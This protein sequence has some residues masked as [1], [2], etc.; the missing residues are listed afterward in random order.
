MIQKLLA[1]VL[2]GILLAVLSSCENFEEEFEYEV[3]SA[4]YEF[5]QSS[6]IARVANRTGEFLSGQIVKLLDQNYSIGKFG[7][8]YLKDR[9]MNSRGEHVMHPESGMIFSFFPILESDVFVQGVERKDVAN[10]FVDAD[11]SWEMRLDQK[12]SLQSQ[13]AVFSDP[14]GFNISGQIEVEFWQ[15]QLDNL[16]DWSS[17]PA[18]MPSESRGSKAG[19]IVFQRVFSLRFLSDNGTPLKLK[20]GS[21]I[22][23]ENPDI[24]DQLK[25]H[26]LWFF[27]TEKAYWKKKNIQ[28]IDNGFLLDQAGYWAIGDE[29]NE[30]LLK[31]DLSLDGVPAI[32]RQLVV[33]SEGRI[34]QQTRTAKNGAFRIYLPELPRARLVLVDSEQDL[35]QEWPLNSGV[36]QDMDLGGL[37]LSQDNEVPVLLRGEV[38]AC[39]NQLTETAMILVENGPDQ[40][41]ISVPPEEFEIELSSSNGQDL[42]TTA[43]DL[44]T[45]E[46]GP[47]VKWARARVNTI[48]LFPLYSCENAKEEYMTLEIEGDY[49]T[50]WTGEYIE[51]NG[52][53]VLENEANPSEFVRLFLNDLSPGEISDS[54]LNFEFDLPRIGDNGYSLSCINSRVGCG[55][56]R[57]VITQSGEEGSR[58]VRGFFEGRFWVRK[59]PNRAVYRDISGSFQIER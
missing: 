58:W 6:V 16:N 35:Q 25:V 31:G 59:L 49:Q 47:R 50:F 17:F 39:D 23:M 4:Q 20:E 10:A 40:Y 44:T 46:Q 15:S 56:E 14:A 33:F 27:D 8:T 51:E 54:L 12:T 36:S 19:R 55:F 1:I 52:R 13:N 5:Y 29:S 9:K 30:H 3:N 11:Q 42:Y 38:R 18:M 53:F 57:F 21:G 24:I 32:N 26:S 37:R 45:E 41:I 22:V 2:L 28:A 43:L 34:V 48:E 7:F